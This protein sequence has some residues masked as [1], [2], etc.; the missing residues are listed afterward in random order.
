V[1]EHNQS[2]FDLFARFETAENNKFSGSFTKKSF[3]FETM[4]ALALTEIE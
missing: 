2:T 4:Q 1:T 3:Y